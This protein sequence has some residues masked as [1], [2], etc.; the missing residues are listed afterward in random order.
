MPVIA[1]F[2]AIFSRIGQLI[3]VKWITGA[4]KTTA[5]YTI[6]LVALAGSIF[7][8]VSLA[9]GML[10]DWVNGLSPI[11]QN[12]LIGIAAFL[13]PNMPYLI[14]AILT[15]YTFSATIHISMEVAK[16]KAQWAEKALGSF[17]A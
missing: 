7:A 2:G 1:F 10:L 4:I 9:N 6:L 17:K 16:L 12:I 8:L 3:L 15:Y 11:G 13:P 5:I 14:S